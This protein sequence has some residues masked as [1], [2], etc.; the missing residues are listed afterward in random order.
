MTAL[1]V[2]LAAQMILTSRGFPDFVPEADRDKIPD[3][4]EVLE[5]TVVDPGWF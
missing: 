3:F 4:D 5:K 1:F 2:A